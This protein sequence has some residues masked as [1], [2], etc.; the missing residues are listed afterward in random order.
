MCDDQPVPRPASGRT[1][2]RNIRANDDVWLP[3]LA[4][5]IAENRSVTDVI[6]DR[7][8]EYIAERYRHAFKFSEYPEALPW[9]EANYPQWANLAAELIEATAG[10][11]DDEY[12]GVAIWL[13]LTR[14]PADVAQQHR[15]ITGFL[16][17]RAATVRRGGWKNRYA[18]SRALTAKIRS[19]LKVHLPEQ[20]T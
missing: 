6:V 11:A 19:I 10:L 3:A 8:R 5:S 20:G 2:L 16:L 13:A 12:M 17:G 9:L 15:V 1:P 7:L 14:H 18:D 4:A